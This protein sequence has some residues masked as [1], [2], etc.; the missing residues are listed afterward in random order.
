V[1][2]PTLVVSATTTRVRRWIKMNAPA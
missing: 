1:T 2:K